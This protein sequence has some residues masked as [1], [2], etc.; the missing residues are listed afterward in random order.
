MSPVKIPLLRRIRSV[1]IVFEDEMSFTETA[2]EDATVDLIASDSSDD[3][4]KC[5]EDLE[6]LQG[7]AEDSATLNADVESS[8]DTSVSLPKDVVVSPVKS[9]VE[10]QSEPAPELS[11]ANEDVTLSLNVSE[12]GDSG[13][14]TEEASSSHVEMVPVSSCDDAL[15]SNSIDAVKFDDSSSAAFS[16]YT[17]EVRTL[18]EDTNRLYEYIDSD[19]GSSDDTALCDSDLLHIKSLTSVHS[20]SEDQQTLCDGSDLQ[21]DSFVDMGKF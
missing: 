5:V 17:S 13:R 8:D 3:S 4:T 15:L 1:E 16:G 12:V 11:T 7:E 14:Y 9:K 21:Y 18:F 2:Y 20:D 10:E 19:S 6:H